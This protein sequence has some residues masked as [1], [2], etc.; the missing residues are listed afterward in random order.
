MI[1]NNFNIRW[2]ILSPYKADSILIID[3]NTVLALTITLQWFK[4]VTRWR[5]EKLQRLSCIQL[6]QFATSNIVE[7]SKPTRIAAFK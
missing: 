1:V 7:R 2:A 4:S 6:R 3:T 5:T